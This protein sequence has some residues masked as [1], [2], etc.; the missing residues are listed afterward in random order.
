MPNRVP[1]EIAGFKFA[2]FTEEDTSQFEQMAAQVNNDIMT[3]MTGPAAASSG[4]AAVVCALDYYDKLKKAE[5]SA[6][7][8]R[9]QIRDYLAE[10]ANAKL[11]IDER[12]RT[13]NQLTRQLTDSSP[14]KRVE[15]LLNQVNTEKEKNVLLY[16]EL[17]SMTAQL[18]QANT[19]AEQLEPL[20]GEL[21]EARARIA[22]LSVLQKELGEANRR[23]SELE[24]TLMPHDPREQISALKDDL[25][26]AADEN[27][28]LRAENA[29]LKKEN[30]G[31]RAE[32]DGLKAEN[33]ALQRAA[34]DADARARRSEADLRTLEG[35]IDE[36]QLVRRCDLPPEGVGLPAAPPV[37]EAPA[38]PEEMPA[39]EPA[40]VPVEEAPA[41]PQSVPEEEPAAEPAEAPIEEAPAAPQSVPEEEPAAEPA[42]A[43][44]EEAPAAP[45]SAPEEMYGTEPA[46]TPA[47]ETPPPSDPAEAPS[48]SAARQISFFDPT[49][50]APIHTEPDWGS[51]TSEDFRRLGIDISSGDD[52]EPQSTGVGAFAG[53][54]DDPMLYPPSARRGD[55]VERL[56]DSRPYRGLVFPE[57]DA[58]FSWND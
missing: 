36:D 35:M 50:D 34:E 27:A 9:N 33:S 45:L 56:D 4:K 55:I 18:E 1:L 41:A 25:S 53:S 49:P 17:D 20:A 16:R 21:A 12:E 43:P 32:N 28:A 40:E 30:S 26:D 7:N 3:I 19:R 31:L 52:F 39:A 5:L 58:G 8:L 29:A 11:I 46:E 57:D 54:Y 42:E 6:V 10:A 44:I 2:V 38:A 22:E 14:S 23:I 24:N 48:A 47:E 51:M 13:I 15:E 37:E